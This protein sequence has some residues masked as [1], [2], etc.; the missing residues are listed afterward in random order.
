MEKEIQEIA[1]GSPTIMG[2]AF[3]RRGRKEMQ[4]MGSVS[5]SEKMKGAL[6]SQQAKIKV[7]KEKIFFRK[8]KPFGW[9]GAPL[10]SMDGKEALET[11]IT[12]KGNSKTDDF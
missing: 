1:C 3:R 7:T 10:Y 4:L 8:L 12:A 2:A 9:N 6:I 5:F 11:R